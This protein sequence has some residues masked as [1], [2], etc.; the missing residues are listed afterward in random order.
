MSSI[1]GVP[2][3]CDSVV[4]RS[5]VESHAPHGDGPTQRDRTRR[6]AALKK[7]HC[8]ALELLVIRAL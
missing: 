6:A 7:R 2:S 4:P 8:V 5:G 3:T 1:K